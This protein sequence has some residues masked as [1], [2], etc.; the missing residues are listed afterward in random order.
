VKTKMLNEQTTR[1]F[2][3]KV[4]VGDQAECWPWTKTLS[5]SGCGRFMVEG[6]NVR[7]QRVAWLLTRTEALESGEAVTNTCGNAACCNPHHL[8]RKSRGEIGARYLRTGRPGHAGRRSLLREEGVVQ[9]RALALDGLPAEEIGKALGVGAHVIHYT[10]RRRGFRWPSK[11][12]TAED[13]W[14][15]I[16]RVR[17]DECWNCRQLGPDGYGRARLAG[18]Q[19]RAHRI[20]WEITQGPIPDGLFVCHRCDNPRCCNPAHLFLGTPADN[21]ADM[22]RKKRSSLGE[23]N[24]S[25]RHG[26]YVGRVRRRR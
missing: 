10:L 16:D 15:G 1:R 20:A 26:A 25:Y 17:P 2:W 5:S 14:A 13:F 8:E 24:G 21:A 18:K 23:R 19:G 12:N 7:A 4:A 11:G 22:A 3:S 9:A 6:Q